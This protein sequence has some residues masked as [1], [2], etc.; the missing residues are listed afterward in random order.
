MWLW[1]LRVVNCVSSG[2]SFFLPNAKFLHLQNEVNEDNLLQNTELKFSRAKVYNFTVTWEGV[3]TYEFN[4]S[5]H[6]AVFM[7]L[8]A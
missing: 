2:K 7:G 5:L 3:R 4:V 8:E 6:P 1:A